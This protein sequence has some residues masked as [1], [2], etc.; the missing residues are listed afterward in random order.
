MINNKN[1]KKNPN[2]QQLYERVVSKTP[3]PEKTLYI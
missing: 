1:K 3:A 2:Q